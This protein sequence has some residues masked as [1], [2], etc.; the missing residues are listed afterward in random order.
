[1]K[2]ALIGAYR[3][4]AK[5]SIFF[6]II[7]YSAPPLPPSWV[8]CHRGRKYLCTLLA[9]SAPDEN[10]SAPLIMESAPD[11]KNLNTPLDICVTCVCCS[12]YALLSVYCLY[13][14]W[15]FK[16]RGQHNI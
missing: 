12:V 5:S 9:Q 7:R 4:D 10:I 2:K 16:T 1:M 3:A 14:P 15:R 11:E 13:R 6:V 8:L